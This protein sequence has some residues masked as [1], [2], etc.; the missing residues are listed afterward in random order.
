MV[1]V[2]LLL[3]HMAIAGLDERK[4]SRI[5]RRSSGRKQVDSTFLSGS[6][7]MHSASHLVDVRAASQ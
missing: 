7:A 6:D 4:L 1:R 3:S 5:W 2:A